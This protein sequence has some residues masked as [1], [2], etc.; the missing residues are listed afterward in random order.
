MSI[1]RHGVQTGVEVYCG[2]IFKEFS[3]DMLKNNLAE[4]IEARY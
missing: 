4:S 3:E 2:L 1:I